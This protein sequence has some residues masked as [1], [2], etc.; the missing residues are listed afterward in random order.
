MYEIELPMV[1]FDF[2]K[3]NIKEEFF[4]RLNKA[5]RLLNDRKDLRVFVGGHTDNYGTDEYNVALGQRRYNEVY[6]YLINKGVDPGQLETG[7]YGEEIPVQ[8][9]RTR[10]GRALNRRVMLSFIQ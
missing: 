6:N 9:N 10:R 1:Y 4:D 5:A 7:T 8:T 2:D 3:H